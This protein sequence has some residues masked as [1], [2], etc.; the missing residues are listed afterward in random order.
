MGKKRIV[1]VFCCRKD[2][3]APLKILRI[4]LKGSSVPCLTER[5]TIG[6]F[7]SQHMSYLL[8]C[9]P[10]V[11]QWSHVPWLYYHCLLKTLLRLFL[12]AKPL[13]VSLQRAGEKVSDVN[14]LLGSL[15]SRA[16]LSGTS[17]PSL[18]CVDRGLHPCL[19]ISSPRDHTGRSQFSS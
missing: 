17:H 8:C 13:S 11:F 1:N 5:P 7:Y 15:V 4:S 19:T 9:N 10:T 18:G 14:S 2:I 3:F 6:A 12:R 16:A